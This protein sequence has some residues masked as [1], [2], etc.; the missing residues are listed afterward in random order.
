[1]YSMLSWVCSTLRANQPNFYSRT[2][3]FIN[4]LYKKKNNIIYK[5]MH[6]YLKDIT[7]RACAA[8]D[9]CKSA[10]SQ[11]LLKLFFSSSWVRKKWR[12]TQR[13]EIASWKTNF[14]F[15]FS[16]K[17]EM[18]RE[19]FWKICL[20]SKCIVKKSFQNFAR[21]L[22]RHSKIRGENS[23]LTY[24]LSNIFVCEKLK[25]MTTTVAPSS[26]SSSRVCQLRN[27]GAFYHCCCY[28]CSIHR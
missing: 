6:I 15:Y 20:I 24:L 2:F 13:Q 17:N 7:T 3:I 11:L 4:Y 5:Y 26:L 10:N 12:A 8:Q 28:Y 9:R 16:R 21:A 19:I 27:G 1:M 25:T 23:F 22:F 18:Q 14:F